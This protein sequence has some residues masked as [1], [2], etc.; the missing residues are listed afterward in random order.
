MPS[1]AGS[2]RGPGAPSPLARPHHR[3]PPPWR[4]RRPRR[5]PPST[6][7]YR[8]PPYYDSLIGKLIVH[9]RRARE[10]LCGSAEPRRVR[11]RWHQDHHPAVPRPD[12]RPRHPGRELWHRL[13]REEAGLGIRRHERAR[14][15]LWWRDTR[16]IT[17][18]WPARSCGSCRR[19]DPKTSRTH[20]SRS[21]QVL[22]R[23]MR[24]GLPDGGVGEDPALY[25]IKPETAGILPLDHF[26]LPQR[27]RRTVA[28]ALRGQGQ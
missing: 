16:R 15:R 11:H 17:F 4:P 20:P 1:N 25:W 6:Q 14:R 27:L 9:G 24:W 13:A 22:L 18:P 2:T 28:R 5:S 10:A 8:I 3:L 19:P 23:P 21:R 7:G 12:R 26:H